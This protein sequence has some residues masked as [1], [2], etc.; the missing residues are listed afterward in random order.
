[1]TSELLVVASACNLGTWEAE[2]ELQVQ[3]HA[4]SEFQA[5]LRGP[6]KTNECMGLGDMGQVVKH[7]PSEALSSNPRT[8]KKKNIY[9]YIYICIYIY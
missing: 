4:C 1:M 2:G 9:I 8:T 5:S 6:V 7:L 3:G